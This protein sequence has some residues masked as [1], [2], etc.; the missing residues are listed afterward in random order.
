MG[1]ACKYDMYR[2]IK[3]EIYHDFLVVLPRYDVYRIGKK[4]VQNRKKNV[5]N[6]KKKCTEHTINVQDVAYGYVH[7]I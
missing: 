4:N 6:R 5:Q 2:K 7:K 1:L 3:I